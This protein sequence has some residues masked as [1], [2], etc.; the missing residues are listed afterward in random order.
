MVGKLLDM[1]VSPRDSSAVDLFPPRSLACA[2]VAPEGA[3]ELLVPR[4]TNAGLE[5]MQGAEGRAGT[6][7]LSIEVVVLPGPPV[8][9]VPDEQTGLGLNMLIT[10]A[11][12]GHRCHYHKLK[13]KFLARHRVAVHS[14]GAG[15]GRGLEY[16]TRR[17][18]SCWRHH[19]KNKRACCE[20]SIQDALE[21]CAHLGE[22]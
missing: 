18:Y 2:T 16:E 15:L 1:P 19:H 21:H 6:S 22:A 7:I 10:S 3:A 4:S 20:G 12:P 11:T 14:G 9:G 17:P 5:D 8:S 13:F